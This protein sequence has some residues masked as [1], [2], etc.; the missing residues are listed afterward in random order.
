MS[1]AGTLLQ[2]NGT[3]PRHQTISQ[4]TPLADLTSDILAAPL[5]ANTAHAKIF[6][7]SE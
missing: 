6:K 5:L 3:S 7:L 1:H 4:K 2:T